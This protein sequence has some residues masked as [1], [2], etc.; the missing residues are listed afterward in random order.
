MDTVYVNGMYIDVS[1]GTHY[2]R[3]SGS[4]FGVRYGASIKHGDLM[5]GLI[6]SGKRYEIISVRDIPNCRY[7]HEVVYRV[8]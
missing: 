7:V 5:R 1:D 2:V 6:K 3:V 4:R 8:Y